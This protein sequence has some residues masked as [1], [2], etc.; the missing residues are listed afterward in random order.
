[1]LV[2]I[3]RLKERIDSK[4]EGKGHSTGVSVVTSC[5]AVTVSTTVS[6]SGVIA[7]AE[8]DGLGGADE[9]Y[10]ESNTDRGRKV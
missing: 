8:E 6:G 5:D 3:Q 10:V 1:M 7:T 9:G 4:N 2:V